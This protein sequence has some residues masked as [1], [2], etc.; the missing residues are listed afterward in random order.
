MARPGALRSRP[1]AT[2][3]SRLLAGLP[4]LLLLLGCALLPLCVLGDDHSH[5]YADGEEVTLWYNKVGPYH[6]PQETYAYS[7]LPWCTPT[8]SKAHRSKSHS[9]GVILE[10]DQLADSGLAV[11]FKRDQELTQICELHIGEKEAERFTNAVQNHYW[12]QMYI[13]ELPIWGMLGEYMMAE[14]PVPS[15]K[16][17]EPTGTVVREQ[18]FL[19]T[20]K[21]F[22][23][24]YNGRQIIEVNLTSENPRPIVPGTTAALTFSVK[25]VE[26]SKPFATR[27]DRYLD[28]DFFEHQ[29]H[30]FSIFN[31]FMMVVFLCGLVAL[32][33]MRTLKNDYVRYTSDADAMELDLDRVTDADSGWKQVHGDVFRSPHYLLLYSAI[34]GTGWQLVAL[35][36]CVIT[37]TLFA[38]MYDERGSAMS[39]FLVCYSLTSLIAGYASAS[40]YKQQGGAE[41]K[42]CM[43]ATAGLFPAVCFGIAFLLNFIAVYYKSLAAFSPGTMLLMMAIWLCVSCPLVLLGT[44]MGRSTSVAGDFPCRVNALRRPIP[45]GK[46]YTR[47][48]ALALLS[49]ILPFGSI[50]IEMYFVFTSFWNYRFYYVYGFMFLVFLML[51]IVTVCVSIVSTYVLL[52]AEDYRWHWSSFASGASTALYVYLYALYYFVTKTR[53]SGVMQTAFYFGYMGMFCVGLAIMTGTIGFVGAN[54]FIRRIY[55]YIKSD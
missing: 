5:S 20:H 11:T 30:W 26:T 39:A 54:I 41:W 19:Y 46:W 51:L 37:L 38:T 42:K 9:L 14:V 13:D 43:L 12:Y 32:I 29:I 22:S 3:S 53:M 31:S 35:C 1:A 40:F 17:G 48:L 45:E 33:L 55:Q 27:F 36:L 15:D 24:S 28:F 25:W 21:E 44:I 34:L 16:P 18:G 10:G 7:S 6:N 47:P 50:F 8:A 2:L 4:A 52:N 23:I 49:G